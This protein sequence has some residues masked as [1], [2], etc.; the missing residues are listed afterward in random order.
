MEKEECVMQME[1]LS[2]CLLCGGQHWQE[3][4]CKAVNVNTAVTGEETLRKQLY[5][6]PTAYCMKIPKRTM[7]IQ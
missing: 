3:N 7:M 4:G 1:A 5:M 6:R 2:Y